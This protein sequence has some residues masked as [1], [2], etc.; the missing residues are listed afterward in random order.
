VCVSCVCPVVLQFVV[1]H[2]FQSICFSSD[3]LSIVLSLG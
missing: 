3:L 1:C 2:L